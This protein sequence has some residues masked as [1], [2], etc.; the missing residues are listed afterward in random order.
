[1]RRLFLKHYTTTQFS[2]QIWNMH[3]WWVRPTI[4]GSQ[5]MDHI[6]PGSLLASKWS[7]T[8]HTAVMISTTFGVL[9]H[10]TERSKHI[11]PIECL[12]KSKVCMN[13][14]QSPSY[15]RNRL[16]DTYWL[17]HDTQWCLIPK[18]QNTS[19]ECEKKHATAHS[20]ASIGTHG[21]TTKCLLPLTWRH[22]TFRHRRC[23]TNP[24][25]IA[26]AERQSKSAC[27]MFRCQLQPDEIKCSEKKLNQPG[28]VWPDAPKSVSVS[29]HG[30][31]DVHLPVLKNA[32][33]GNCNVR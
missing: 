14:T 1:M 27:L 33:D 32:R 28:P 11:E 13:Y 10:P 23:S 15:K 26:K 24:Q 30:K 22:C 12:A 3:T 25:K 4:H 21:T 17:A 2:W 9:Q 6:P 19:A 8:A 16:Y 18:H 5:N 29:A 20:A 7:P 31:I